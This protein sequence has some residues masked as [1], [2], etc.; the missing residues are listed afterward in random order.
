[1]KCLLYERKLESKGMKNK[2]KKVVS[3]TKRVP[4]THAQSPE[5]FI[6]KIHVS[7]NLTILWH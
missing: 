3:E 1:M 5:T 6:K 7:I 2:T 4:M